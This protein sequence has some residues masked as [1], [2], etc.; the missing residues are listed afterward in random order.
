[1]SFRLGGLSSGL[2]TSTMVEQLLQ[3]ERRPLYGIQEKQN[4]VELK[5]DL[6]SG[7]NSSLTDLQ[8]KVENLLKASTFDQISASSS[9]TDIIDVSYDDD[10]IVGTYNITVNHLASNTTVASSNT[11]EGTDANE[12]AASV[13]TI[14]TASSGGGIDTK[15]TFADA[16]FSSAIK[17]GTVTINGVSFSIDA[18]QTT[19]DEFLNQV[20]SN[21]DAGVTMSYDSGTDKFTITSKDKGSDAS[22][23]LSDTTDFFTAIDI[24][25]SQTYKG[26]GTA[27]PS[28]KLASSNIN[29]LASD[30]GA[31]YF[32]ING[33]SFSFDENTHSLNHV[34]DTI[35]NSGVGVTAFYDADTDKVFM[36]S[37][38][39]GNE[40]LLKKKK[41]KK[42]KKKFNYF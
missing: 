41:K 9:D 34:I 7:I 39:T 14:T 25:S 38:E 5:K 27:D 18:D 15:K 12:T 16:G 22:I 31:F 33:Y 36:S 42:K 37:K 35:N 1:M 23:K 17:D 29:G 10:A 21:S 19:V 28:A 3:L 24:D 11:L 4:K 32:K 13:T 20:N 26:S 6:L 8:A 30:G 2:D 40:N